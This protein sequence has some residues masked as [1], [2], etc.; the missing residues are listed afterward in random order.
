[1]GFV[2]NWSFSDPLSTACI[3]GPRLFSMSHQNFYIYNITAI[4]SIQLIRNFTADPSADVY[5]QRLAIDK[6]RAYISSGV[7]LGSTPILY[8]IDISDEVN[9]V[10]LLPEDTA[11]AALPLLSV[12]FTLSLVAILKPYKKRKKY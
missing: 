12:L 11:I 6:T 4:D 3:I 2:N 5:F 8:L 7:A 10:Q 9:L 1:L